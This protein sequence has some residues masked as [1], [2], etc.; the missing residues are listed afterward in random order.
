M[1]PVSNSTAEVLKLMAKETE[2][3]QRRSFTEVMM[4]SKKETKHVMFSKSTVQSLKMPVVLTKKKRRAPAKSSVLKDGDKKLAMKLMGHAAN[5][6]SNVGE[7]VSSHFGGSL[8]RH[9]F[10]NTLVRLFVDVDRCL[11]WMDSSLNPCVCGLLGLAPKTPFVA[12]SV[13]KPN[14][15]HVAPCIDK[16]KAKKGFSGPQPK[17]SFKPIVKRGSL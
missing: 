1:K 10:T 11:K 8:E 3:P 12:P 15:G 17:N 7:D 6:A 4:H 2:F 16:R 9:S 5:L 14:A 13:R